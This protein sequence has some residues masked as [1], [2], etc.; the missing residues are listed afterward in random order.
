MNYGLYNYQITK[1]KQLPVKNACVTELREWRLLLSSEGLPRE[2][3]P[4]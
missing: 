3:P 2:D 4:L 1:E